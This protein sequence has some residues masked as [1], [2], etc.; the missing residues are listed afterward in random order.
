M[1]GGV[2]LIAGLFFLAP[3]RSLT[4]TIKGRLYIWKVNAPHLLE[5]PIFGY[6]PGGFE[7]KYIEWETQFWRLGKG[8][9]RGERLVQL[10]TCP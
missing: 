10:R 4:A 8:T 7:P 5:R 1:A 3:S 2:L 9:A 6:G